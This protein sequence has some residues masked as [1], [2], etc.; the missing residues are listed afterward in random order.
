[1]R[2][3]ATATFVRLYKKLPAHIRDLAKKAL[4]LFEADPSHPSLVHKKMAGQKNIYEFRVSQ[5]YRITY[6][7]IQDTAC[8]RKI[9]THDLLRNP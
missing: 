2:V 8:L 3:E 5:N 9:G 6:Q 1:M 4:Q 7:K